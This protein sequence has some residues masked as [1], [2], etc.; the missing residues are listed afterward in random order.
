M[1]KEI[2]L[3]KDIYNSSVETS[4]MIDLLYKTEKMISPYYSEE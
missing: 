4:E 1:P 3:E 2:K